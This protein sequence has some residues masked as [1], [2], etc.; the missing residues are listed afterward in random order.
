MAL[1]ALADAVVAPV[2][3]AIKVEQQY[4]LVINVQLALFQRM[5][6]C[7]SNKE[8]IS[9]TRAIDIPNVIPTRLEAG[10][11]RIG[12]DGPVHPGENFFP[13]LLFSKTAEYRRR[14]IRFGMRRIDGCP[15]A[16]ER[17]PDEL[18]DVSLKKAVTAQAEFVHYSNRATNHVAPPIAQSST[19]CA[20]P[21]HR[22]SKHRHAPRRNS[23]QPRWHLSSSSRAPP[24]PF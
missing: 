7:L 11:E 14:P 17:I 16:M 4:E 10:R 13:H 20:I 6:I 22:L 9:R 24:W 23:C 15:C 2:V 5:K 18:Q 3:A 1:A 8:G 19:E 12:M 21:C